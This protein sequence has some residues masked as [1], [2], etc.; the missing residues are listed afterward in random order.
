IPKTRLAE[1]ITTAAPA[2]KDLPLSVIERVEELKTGLQRNALGKSI[3]LLDG[4][5]PIIQTW[6]PQN[7]SPAIPGC[8]QRRKPERRGVEIHESIAADI[9]TKAALIGI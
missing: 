8:E 1:P 3:V 5:I 9:I 7:I 6:R 4:D 2:R